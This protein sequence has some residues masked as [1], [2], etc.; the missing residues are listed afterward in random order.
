MPCNNALSGQFV[1]T[2][3]KA[4]ATKIQQAGYYLPL[5]PHSTPNL[6]GIIHPTGIIH[7]RTL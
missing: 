6:T 3:F 1:G 4:S 5:H 7:L 2:L